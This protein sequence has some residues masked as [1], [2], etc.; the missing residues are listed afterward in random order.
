[1]PILE[2]HALGPVG[3]GYRE[4]YLSRRAF[5]RQMDWLARH[6][7]HPVTLDQMWAAWHGT[8]GSRDVRS[9]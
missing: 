3:P 6:R 4:L 2:Y 7:Y 1:M 8:P 9:C 5:T